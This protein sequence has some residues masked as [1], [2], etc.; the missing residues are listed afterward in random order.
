MQR[1]VEQSLSMPAKTQGAA[2][3]VRQKL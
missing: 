2:H 1:G 3:S